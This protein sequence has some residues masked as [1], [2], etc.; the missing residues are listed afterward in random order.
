M[1]SDSE[2]FAA[3]PARK[4]R[5][6]PPDDG[7]E[8]QAFLQMGPHDSKRRRIIVVRVPDGQWKGALMPIPFLLFADETVEDTDETLM[9]L[10]QEIMLNARKANDNLR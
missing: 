6:R 2:F 5:I 1:A 9:P 10:V 8:R 7:E 4:A 3:F